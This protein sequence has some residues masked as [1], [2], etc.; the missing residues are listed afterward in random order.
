MTKKRSMIPLCRGMIHLQSR[1]SEK[2]RGQTTLEPGFAEDLD[3]S[4]QIRSR[5]PW[6]RSFPRP[7]SMSATRTWER[8]LSPSR[9]TTKD[10]I[11]RWALEGIFWALSFPCVQDV[12]QVNKEINRKEYLFPTSWTILMQHLDHDINYVTTAPIRSRWD[13]WGERQ[14]HANLQKSSEW[15]NPTPTIQK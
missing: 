2:E 9:Y 5:R 1:K 12:L 13:T 3:R 15:T 10:G 8:S 6:G 11:S 14:E 7:P 4:S